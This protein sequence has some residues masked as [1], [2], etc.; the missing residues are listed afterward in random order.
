MSQDQSFEQACSGYARC[1]DNLDLARTALMRLDG[2]VGVGIGPKQRGTKLD[3]S[4]VCFLVYVITKQPAA[5]LEANAFIPVK[6]AGVTTDVVQ[7]GSRAMDVHNEFDARWLKQ[8]D[9]GCRQAESDDTR[10][11]G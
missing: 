9:V 2:V 5:E 1:Y 6:L 4:D 10:L 11:A 8:F 7:V 3:T